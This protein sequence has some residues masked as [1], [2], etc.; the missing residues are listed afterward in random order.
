MIILRISTVFV[1]ADKIATAAR[2]NCH[3]LPLSAT[4]TALKSTTNLYA[5]RIFSL[6]SAFAPKIQSGS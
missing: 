2:S 4:G 6:D 3:T 1:Y 5:A